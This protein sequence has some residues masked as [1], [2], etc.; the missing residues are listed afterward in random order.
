VLARDNRVTR[1]ADF[2]TAVRKGRRLST[3]SVVVHLVA[4]DDSGPTRFGFIVTKA[5]GGAVVRNRV[6]RRLRA[7]CRDILPTMESG[8][9]V[10]VRALPASV[11][12]TWGTLHSEITEAIEKGGA[13]A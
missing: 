6:R 7:V 8:T 13:S 2:R 5:V 9:N 11:D 12:V 10:V 1:P 3:S 4:R